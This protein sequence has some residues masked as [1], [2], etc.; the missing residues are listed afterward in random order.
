MIVL[1]KPTLTIFRRHCWLISAFITRYLCRECYSRMYSHVYALMVL[2]VIY[3]MN[4]TVTFQVCSKRL[5]RW[6]SLRPGVNLRECR[7]MTYFR[8]TRLFK[9][10][11]R[12]WNTA[13]EFG[14]LSMTY[15]YIFPWRRFWHWYWIPALQYRRTSIRNL[16][17]TRLCVWGT[18]EISV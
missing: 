15:T 2:K 10:R 12:L 5:F 14:N 7:V 11:N 3:L 17:S 4:T 18:R 6:R 13:I 1:S 8:H 9:W 16:S